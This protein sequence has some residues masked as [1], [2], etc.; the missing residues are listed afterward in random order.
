MHTIMQKPI[1]DMSFDELD[2]LRA[3]LRIAQVVLCQRG[4]L[5]PTTYSRWRRWLRGDPGGTPPTRR[6]TKVVRDVLKA[7]MI[8]RISHPANQAPAR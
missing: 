5:N 6:S 4:D 3:E 8:R 7:E 2:A 1:D